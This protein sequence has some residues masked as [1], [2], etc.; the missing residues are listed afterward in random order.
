MQTMAPGN[1]NGK[2]T[3]RRRPQQIGELTSAV[4]D[5]VL[6]RRAG[7]SASLIHSWDEVVGTKLAGSTLPQKVQWPRR[8]G[9]DDPFQPATLTIAADPSVAFVLQHE[10]QQVI[11]R[12]NAFLGYAA[13]DRIRI[14]QRPVEFEK[15]P[16]P[17]AAPLSSEIRSRLDN[18]VEPIEDDGL[19]AS[20]RRLG[21][22]VAR[23][24]GRD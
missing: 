6:E 5:P 24:S 12:V 7:I 15:R 14:L 1:Q 13:I 20:L 8:A 16:A 11:E 4:L 9:Q 22:S 3:R 10:T 2:S 18:T 17:S 21:E 23:S 19:R